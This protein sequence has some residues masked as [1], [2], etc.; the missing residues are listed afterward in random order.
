MHTGVG[1]VGVLIGH[2]ELRV[3]GD[4]LARQRDGPVGTRCAGRV[5]DLRAVERDQLAPLER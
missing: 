2:H 3:A 5:D 4:E 1:R